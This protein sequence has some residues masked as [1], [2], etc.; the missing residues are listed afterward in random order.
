MRPSK[1]RTILICHVMQGSSI[2]RKIL[3]HGAD[4][5]TPPLKEGM[6]QIFIALKNPSPWLGLNSRTLGP[7]TSMLTSPKLTNTDV[8]GMCFKGTPRLKQAC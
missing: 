3:R 8:L 2:C 5:F 4:G 6:M 7:M 1:V